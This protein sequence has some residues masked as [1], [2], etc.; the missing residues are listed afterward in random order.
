MAQGFLAG[1]AALV[2]L[3]T[4]RHLREGRGAKVALLPLAEGGQIVLTG[5]F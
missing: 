1:G 4:A 3:A 5:G 2:G